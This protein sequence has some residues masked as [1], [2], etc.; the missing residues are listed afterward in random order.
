MSRHERR[1]AAALVRSGERELPTMA[2][3]MT[4]ALDMLVPLF[5]DCAVAILAAPIGAPPGARVHWGSNGHREDMLA[6]MKEFIARAEGRAIGD[7][8]A[9]ER[10]Q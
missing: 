6:M 10:V 4:A 2:E 5:P 3:R 8:D 1:R 7:H 9:P